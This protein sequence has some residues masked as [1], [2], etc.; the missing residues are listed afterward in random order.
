MQPLCCPGS[1]QQSQEVRGGTEAISSLPPRREAKGRWGFSPRAGL[2]MWEQGSS[3][4]PHPVLCPAANP[5]SRRGSPC[6]CTR[7]LFLFLYN[8]GLQK[9]PHHNPIKPLTVRKEKAQYLNQIEMEFPGLLRAKDDSDKQ[10]CLCRGNSC[11]GPRP[12]QRR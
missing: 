11:A 4:H 6:L 3:W 12:L 5:R 1:A 2:E 9:R 8:S 7:G 10:S